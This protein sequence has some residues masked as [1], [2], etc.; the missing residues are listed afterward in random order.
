[1][2]SFL[3]IIYQS[4]KIFEIPENVRDFGLP[5]IEKYLPFK[6]F[7]LF[8]NFLMLIVQLSNNSAVRKSERAET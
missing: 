3:V 4:G 7:I 1:M 8:F 2:S 5:F 6:F